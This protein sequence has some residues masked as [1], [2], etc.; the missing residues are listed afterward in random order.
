[1]PAPAEFSEKKSGNES[2]Y[3]EKATNV[4]QQSGQQKEKSWQGAAKQEK[5][6]K[7]ENYV[8]ALCFSRFALSLKPQ[9]F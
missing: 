5:G 6:E 7:A 2:I 4:R 8:F 1:M 3:T 9:S